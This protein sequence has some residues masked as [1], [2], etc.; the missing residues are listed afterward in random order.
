MHSQLRF[1]VG[2]LVQHQVLALTHF[3]PVVLP[4][5]T[6]QILQQAD[7]LLLQARPG[8]HLLIDNRTV[9]MSHLVPL[10]FILDTLPALKAHFLK[11]IVV[12]VPENLQ[13]Q[14]RQLPVEEVEDIQLHHVLG[15]QEA[16]Q[17]LHPAEEQLHW[18]EKF[19][20]PE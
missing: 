10:Q 20:L 5:D 11:S 8:F 7:H 14:A 1:K 19:F 2:W 9:Q 4:E 3:D 6:R 17:L 16:F 15:L 13:Q 12:M 18:D